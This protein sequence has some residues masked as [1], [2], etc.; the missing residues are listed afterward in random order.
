MQT[1]FG[2]NGEFV[3]QQDYQQDFNHYVDILIAL[4]ASLADSPEDVAAEVYNAA[5]D[6]KKQLHYIAGNHATSEYDWLKKE[7]VE[8]V[9]NTMKKRFFE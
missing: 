5:T 4:T 1:N 3:T 8:V 2:S 9:V 6:G 7:G